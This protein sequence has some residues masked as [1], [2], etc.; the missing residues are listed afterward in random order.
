MKTD[1]GA[2]LRLPLLPAVAAGLLL[3]GAPP[4]PGDDDGIR[5]AVFRVS[6]TSGQVAFSRGD[7]PD[8]WQ[9]AM[10]NVPLTLG[11]RLW[12]DRGS[13]AELQ[14]P[15]ARVF[16]APETQL[17]VLDVRDDIVQMS[18]AVGTAAVRLRHLSEG[19][20]FEV[21]TPNAAVTLRTPG[22]YRFRV[23]EDGTT[24]VEVSEGSALAAVGREV[25]ELRRGDA[26][27]V[28]GLD[29]PFYELDALPAPD[30][31][32]RWTDER[33][34]HGRTV[35]SAAYVGGGITGVEDLDAWGRWERIPEYGWAWSPRAVGSGWTPYRDGRWIWQDPWG[36]TWVSREAWGWAPYHYGSWVV[37]SGRWFWVP[38]GPRVRWARYAPARVVF[39]GAGPGG[40]ALAAASM[41]F[42]GWFPIHPHDRF[43]PWWGPR[44][45]VTVTTA[46][47]LNR[48]H[49]TVVGR[50][51]FVGGGFV[52]DARVRDARLVRQISAA[53]PL[54]GPIPLVPTTA[55]IRLSTPGPGSAPPRPPE[56][57][58]ERRVATGL[59]PPPSPPAFNVKVDAI[60]QNS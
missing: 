37:A 33:D 17:S 45:V 50:E 56:R 30:A 11:D 53:P 15:G 59:P 10:V 32:D 12:A 16:V 31:F 58:L 27:L 52:R 6:Y 25:A 14:V 47:Y 48:S 22:R 55:S 20:I 49:V 44:A 38:E 9:E 21:D 29:E 60:R 7:D 39:V 18:L 43:V 42:I 41:A 4:A 35:V 3:L 1:S 34:V 54:T 51:T 19:E 23:D 26:L 2:R 24:R 13:R 46:S 28:R 5:Q 36:W 57:Y 8:H 40:I